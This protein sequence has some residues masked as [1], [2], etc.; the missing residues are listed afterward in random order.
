MPQPGCIVC[1]EVSTAEVWPRQ[2]PKV[3]GQMGFEELGA[4]DSG[5]VLAGIVLTGLL[6]QPGCK[7]GGYR[8]VTGSS[9]GL[10]ELVDH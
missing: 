9:R 3:A 1:T 5:V 8:Q 7:A 6:P 4:E 10:A 2:P